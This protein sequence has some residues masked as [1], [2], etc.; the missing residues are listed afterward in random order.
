MSRLINWFF[1]CIYIFTVLSLSVFL[2]FRFLHGKCN[3]T[4]CRFSHKLDKSKVSLPDWYFFICLFF[5]HVYFG[6][7]SLCIYIFGLC[8]PEKPLILSVL[9]WVHLFVCLEFCFRN[10][11]WNFWHKVRNPCRLKT[12]YCIFEKIL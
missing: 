11:H 1:K 10:V 8:L 12:G 2:L 5:V 6:L 3:D 9:L 7:Y 4:D